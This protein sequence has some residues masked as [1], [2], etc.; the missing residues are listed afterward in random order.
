MRRT[1]LEGHALAGYRAAKACDADNNEKMSTEEIV[2]LCK[3][4]GLPLS[5]GDDA[6]ESMDADGSGTLELGEFVQWWIKRCA[7]VP[8]TYIHAKKMAAIHFSPDQSTVIDDAIA[9]ALADPKNL[10]SESELRQQANAAFRA[11]KA[12]D[13]DG[14]EIITTS[15]IEELTEKMGLPVGEGADDIIVSMDDDGSGRLEIMEFVVWWIHRV[16]RLPGTDKQQEI[17]ARNTFKNFDKDQS[18]TITSEELVDIVSS[19]GVNFSEEELEEALAEL[20]TDHSGTIDQNEFM[21]WWMN[22]ANSVRPGASLI[23]YK[24]KKIAQ[25]AAQVYYTDIH[26]AAWKGDLDLVSMFLDATPLL[27]NAGDVNEHGGGWTP[28]QY[29]C[30]QGHYDIVVDMLSRQNEKKQ[31]ICNIDLQNDQKFTALFYAAQRKHL[32]ICRLLL[33]RGADPT[34]CGDHHVDPD[35]HV[36]PADHAEDSE[37]L[38]ELF[39]QNSKCTIP[40]EVASGEIS[41]SINANGVVCVELPNPAAVDSLSELPLTKWRLRLNPTGSRSSSPRCLEVLV[42]ASRAKTA[43]RQKCEMELAKADASVFIQAATDNNFTI[44]IAARNAVGE[45]PF[46]TPVR[47][48]VCT[49]TPRSRMSRGSL[50]SR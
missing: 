40:L 50:N 22:R 14:N 4:L 48:A 21:E 37:Q 6:I 45:G 11:A 23:A 17:I 10:S 13:H 39:M 19:L 8:G 46:S 28:L 38:R 7:A 5:D 35:I 2:E 31:L 47:V 34:L 41:A 24:L 20:D 12:S 43:S 49:V 16:S 15:E 30:Y 25:K 42:T 32:E 9:K 3:R 18:G 33:E 44:T 26:T 36:C 29:A 1:E 27:C